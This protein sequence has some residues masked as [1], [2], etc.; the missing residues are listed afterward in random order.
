M[1]D[2]AV[3]LRYALVTPARDEAAHIAATI[4]SVAAQTQAPE[5]WVIVDDA[6]SDGT[7]EVARTAARGLDWV[8]VVRLERQG[9]DSFSAK[10][11]AFET[12]LAALDG[13][14][15]DLI[16]NVDADVTFDPSFFETLVDEFAADPR[17]GVSGGTVVVRHLGRAEPQRNSDGNV[18][19]AAQLFRRTCFEGV[20]GFVPLPLGGE[21]AAAQIAARASGWTVRTVERLEVFHDDPVT[22]RSRSLLGS[23]F[24]KGITNYLLGY[25]PVFHALAAASR[26]GEPPLVLG[27]VWML[28]GYWWGAIRWRSRA[29]SPEV[30][31]YLRR[32]QRARLRRALPW[33]TKP[34]GGPS[35][36]PSL[37]GEP[38]QVER[39]ERRH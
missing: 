17:L 33:R 2:G 6:S 34:T 23:R 10:V 26:L 28:A 36:P 8:D 15:F 16:G 12:G 32:E 4:A 27:S 37:A 22:A 25:D 39:L 7:A 24:R 18:P 31:S 9:G 20:G 1:S 3:R 13:V 11:H 35:S 29:V 38:H 30:V 14:P 19:G 21:D 5:R